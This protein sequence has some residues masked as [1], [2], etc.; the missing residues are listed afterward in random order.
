MHILG[1]IDLSFEYSQQRTIKYQVINAE[2]IV[3][4]ENGF[5]LNFTHYSLLFKR[6]IERTIH[7]RIIKKIN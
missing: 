4:L 2:A 7:L 6:I 1:R 3:Q 5:F